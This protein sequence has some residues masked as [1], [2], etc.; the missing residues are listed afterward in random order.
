MGVE[1]PLEFVKARVA[2]AGFEE[3]LRSLLR[4]SA[5]GYQA[6]LVKE[7]DPSPSHPATLLKWWTQHRSQVPL[8]PKGAHPPVPL[9]P[10]R[11]RRRIELVQGQ[12]GVVIRL[13]HQHLLLGLSEA[14]EKAVRMRREKHR[15]VFGQRFEQA[16]HPNEE[17]GMQVEIR[18]IERHQ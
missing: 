13:A 4:R 11:Q 17:R 15:D 18:F 14:V 5:P 1:A 6:V 12:S 16:D 9:Q 2:E 3:P 7:N 8:G 10:T